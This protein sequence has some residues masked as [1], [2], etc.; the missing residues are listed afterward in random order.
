VA[1]T[2][3][4]YWSDFLAAHDLVGREI[5]I[6]EGRDLT[7]LGAEIKVMADDTS[8]EETDDFYPGVVVRADGFVAVGSC[9]AGSGDPYF[10]N[11]HDGEG[12]P[13]YRIYHDAVSHDAYDR[14]A[15]VAIVLKDYREL[16]RYRR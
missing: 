12:G 3:P 7:G 11:V 2:Q 10:I 1:A 6:P 13:L 16:L 15:A 14:D 5:E 4:K 8:R 9:W